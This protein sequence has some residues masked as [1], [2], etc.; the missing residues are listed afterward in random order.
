MVARLNHYSLKAELDHCS[1]ELRLKSVNENDREWGLCI[2]IA[3]KDKTQECCAFFSSDFY[4][5]VFVTTY[6]NLVK[7]KLI[8]EISLE[9]PTGHWND[10]FIAISSLQ[11]MLM[12]YRVNEEKKLSIYLENKM[13]DYDDCPMPL[14]NLYILIE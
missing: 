6:K 1:E 8:K 4:D 2:A 5:D 12:T 10:V 9:S 13:D 3:S 7:G 11:H 14:T